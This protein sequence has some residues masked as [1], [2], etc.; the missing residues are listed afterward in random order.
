MF[1][2]LETILELI[3]LLRRLIADLARQDRDLARQIRRAANGMLLNTSEARQRAGGDRLHLYRTGLGSACEVS[4]ALRAA[5]A[6]GFVR[7]ADVAP[8]EA[9]LDRIRAMLWRLANPRR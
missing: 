5:V 7:E 6:W 2:V 4:D 8:L 9:R 1:D 3:R